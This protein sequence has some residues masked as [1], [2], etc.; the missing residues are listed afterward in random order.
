MQKTIISDTSC[1]II[2]DNI[3]ELGLLNKVFGQILITQDV[4]D[5]YG[6]TLPKWISIQNPVNKKY[7]QLLEAK[8]DKGEASAIALAFELQNCLLILDDLKARNLAD[9]LGIEITGTFGV[10]LEAKL[11]GIIKSVNPILNKIKQTD[12]RLSQK[13]EERV[14]IKAGEI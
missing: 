8:V 2:L 5:E 14:L 11:S 1:L 12:F 7:Q 3:G 4:A 6:S 13:L 10:I 9:E